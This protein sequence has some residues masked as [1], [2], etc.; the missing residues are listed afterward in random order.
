MKPPFSAIVDTHGVT[1][2]R[3]CRAHLGIHDADDAWSETFLAALRA[4]PELPETAN[5][6]AWLATIARRKVIDLVRATHRHPLPM[7]EVPE[8]PIASEESVIADRSVWDAVAQLPDKQRRV[9]VLRYL[10]GLSYA[11]VAAITGGTA[12][13]ARRAAADGLVTLRAN[14]LII[15]GAS[16]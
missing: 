15:E 2:L 4:Y 1:V 16:S 7:Y 10:A 5:V 6:E 8:I 9:V 12:A 14:P 3:I 13:A 11:E